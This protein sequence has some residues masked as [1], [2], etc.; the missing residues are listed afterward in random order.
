[1]DGGTSPEYF[2]YHLVLRCPTAKNKFY[3]LFNLDL[4]CFVAQHFSSPLCIFFIECKN[5]LQVRSIAKEVVDSI[6][7]TV[8][9]ADRVHLV[10]NYVAHASV[11]LTIRN[12]ALQHEKNYCVSGNASNAGVHNSRAV[13][14][15][16]FYTVEPNICWLSARNLFRIAIQAPWFLGCPLNFWKI[17]EPFISPVFGRG[18]FRISGAVSWVSVVFLCFLTKRYAL[19]K[20]LCRHRSVP[21]HFLFLKQFVRKVAVHLQKVLELMSTNHSE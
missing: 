4:L 7:N 13:C 12:L 2:G 6:A 1:M 15:H 10:W 8:K 5:K 21:Y 14:P 11:R 20:K 19:Y 9:V 17:F 16:G 3:F 18:S